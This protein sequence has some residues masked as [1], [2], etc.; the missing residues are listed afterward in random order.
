MGKEARSV[1]RKSF[2]KSK[3]AD[4]KEH[5]KEVAEF[6]KDKM[7]HVETKEKQ[8]L[9][10]ADAIKQEKREVELKDGIQKFDKRTSLKPTVTE[11]KNTL[12]DQKTIE[13]EKT[14]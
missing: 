4:L 6:D 13:E 12:P 7:S 3:M 10:D 11:V 14:A 8:V 9:P 2:K 5:V 1:L